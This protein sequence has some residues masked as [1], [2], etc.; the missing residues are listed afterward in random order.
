MV[1]DR[2]RSRL[3]R[4]T[5]AALCAVFTLSACASGGADKETEEVALIDPVGVALHYEKAAVRNLYDAKTYSALVCPTVEEYSFAT[6]QT[7]EDYDAYP[8][9]SVQKGQLLMHANT[10]SLDEQIEDL[11]ES[12][13][14]MDESYEE[15]VQDYRDNLKKPADDRAFYQSVLENL[16]EQEPAQRFVESTD[17]N[18]EIVR[19][20]TDAYNMWAAEY[21]KYDG[22]FRSSDLTVDKINQAYKERTELYQLDRQYALQ[23]LGY[24]KEDMG[25]CTISSKISGNVVAL[26]YLDK[27]DWVNDDVA[28]MAVGDTERPVLRS[29]YISKSAYTRAEAV[30]AIINGK[31]YE[32]EYVPLEAEEYN[33]LEEKNGKV[34]S[35]FYVKEDIS[36]IPMGSYAVIVV[37]NKS[38]K[39]VLSVPKD[40]IKRD[41]SGN[42]V[43]LVEDDTTV[44]TPVSVG[45]SDGVYTEILS[46]VREGDKV[47]TDNASTTGKKVTKLESGTVNNQF[48]GSGFL[49]YPSA[50]YADNPVTYGTCYYVENLVS[51]YQQVQKGDV[52]A[53]VRVVPDSVELERNQR[54]LQRETERLATL[55]KQG[56]EENKKT[57]AAKEKTIRELEEKIAEMN[58]DAA[59]KEIKA[60][61]NG[62]VTWIAKHEAQD[63]LKKDEQ[64]YMIADETHSYVYVEDSKGILTYGNTAMI[65]YTGAD[66]KEKTA[67]GT[68]VTLNSM[69]ISK[70]LVMEGAL[71]LLPTDSIGE[72]AGSAEGTAGAWSRNHFKVNVTIRDMQNVVLVPKSAVTENSGRTYVQ[73]KQKDGTVLLQS[74]VAGGSDNAYYWVAEGLEE[75]M[76][77]C[78]E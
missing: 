70:D 30:Y 38:M 46:G 3:L 36:D 42:F 51:E 47:L 39:N 59:V 18:G 34:Y 32:V 78:S 56:E 53:T 74:F 58:R 5:A 49:L 73:L 54:K 16:D 69:A 26:Q 22:L 52:L 67:E 60:P 48:S 75:G 40:S 61:I 63:I 62:I 6:G 4:V 71:I 12:I 66:K 24:L 17:A 9:Q 33:R 77:I 19:T 64:L 29:E 31:H 28:V 65:S 21:Q 13:E 76:E 37:I 44:Q 14:D 23:R 57:I 45:Y 27:G 20:Q 7:F 2:N 43:Y 35:T 15:Y 41:E 55:R 72:I 25:D 1:T 50:E 11:N 8:G 10:E 68:V